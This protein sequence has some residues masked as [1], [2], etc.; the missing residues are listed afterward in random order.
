MTHTF[1]A[2][3]KINL[4][5]RVSRIRAD[6]MHELDTAFAYAELSDQLRIS[7]AEGIKVECSQ[8]HLSGEKNLVHQILAAFREKHGIKQ[9]LYVYIDKHIPE[10]AGLGGGSSDAA[11]ALMA[12]NRLWG[13]Q[14]T[15]D[16]LIDFAT[17]FG[18]D[19]PCFIYGR[20]S[21]AQGVGE[22]LQDYPLALPSDALLLARPATGLSTAEV[23]RHFDRSHHLDRT[24]TT[25]EVLDTIRRDSPQLAENDLEASACSLNADVAGL[26]QCLRSYSDRVWMSGSGSA[27]IALF[28][29]R[30][31]ANEVAALLK[32]QQ[33]A[34]WSH[35][36][37]IK[38]LHPMLI[39]T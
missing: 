37:R 22:R 27:C 21:L 35:V 19:I 16:A 30:L 36:G 14:A 20:A 7:M 12:A 5:L 4:H 13:V 38:R 34:N 11:T 32:Q 17:P 39:G 26:L 29:H 23:F 24:L 2:P 15:M 10:Q 18:A 6:G 8:P 33:V 28:E 1:P 31:Q 25:S 9:G 3:A